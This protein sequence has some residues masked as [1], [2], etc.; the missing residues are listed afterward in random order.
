MPTQHEQRVL[1]VEDD[2]LLAQVLA[3]S[4]NEVKFGVLN[5]YNGLEVLDAAKKFEP[6]VIL[7]DLILPGIDGFEVL[8]QLKA[9]VQTKNIPVV[10]ISNLTDAADIKSAL[11]LGAVEYF[12][13]ANTQLEKIV[14][15]VKKIIKD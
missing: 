1:I 13:K 9:D 11:A 15:F 10:I 6:A 14:D 5:I 12:I 2:A 7:L 8:K 4:F 3:S